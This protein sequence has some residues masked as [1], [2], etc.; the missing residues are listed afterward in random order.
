MISLSLYFYKNKVKIEIINRLTYEI[1]NLY[2]GN[3]LNHINKVKCLKIK[4]I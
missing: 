2:N 3:L 1:P 4:K